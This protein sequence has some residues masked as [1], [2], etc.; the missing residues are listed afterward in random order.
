MKIGSA[1]LVSQCTKSGGSRKQEIQRE[2]GGFSQGS[3]KFGGKT[4]DV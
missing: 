1:F 3:E 4:F 2:N